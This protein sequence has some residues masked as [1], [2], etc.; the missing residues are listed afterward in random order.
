[1]LEN[2]KGDYDDDDDDDDFDTKGKS[3]I[4][5]KNINCFI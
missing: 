3:F 5:N 2:A 4:N 1:M